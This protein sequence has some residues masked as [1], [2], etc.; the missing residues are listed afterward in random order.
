ME[1]FLIAFVVSIG[2]LISTLSAAV[3][4]VP[5]DENESESNSI[6][7]RFESRVNPLD[8][9]EI[10]AYLVSAIMLGVTLNNGSHPY[11]ENYIALF[12]FLISFLV[13]RYIFVG[14]GIR[15]YSKIFS[16]FLPLYKLVTLLVSPFSNMISTMIAAISNENMEDASRNEISALVESA[17][18]EGSLDDREYRIL[19]NI[20]HFSD[21][22]V[23]DVMTPRTMVFSA[24]TEA[25][26][27]DIIS[28]P[29]LKM[30]S[31]F[32]IWSGESLDE[33]ID[34]YVMTRD[35]L[36]AALRGEYDIKLSKFA[37]EVYYIPEN[38]ELD[39]ALDKFLKRKQHLFMVVDE[40]GG[41]EGLL[42]MED[43][44][45]TILG[46]EIVDEADRFEDLREIAKQQR[47]RRI[48]QLSSSG[49]IINDEVVE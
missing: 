9:L 8:I 32:P 27:K 42:S 19:K 49:E 23:S 15:F 44:L 29:E 7:S 25:T 31:R 45:E 16:A 36:H 20:M 12:L 24:K 35:V 26:V 43:V 21:I 40:Y 6:R 17:R 4:S 41:I 14:I 28:L 33:N 11:Y 2:F 10:F 22:L 48:S 47:D 39:V 38:A 5:P 30:Y 34:G 13:L 18:E 1:Y 37:R 3:T 46:V